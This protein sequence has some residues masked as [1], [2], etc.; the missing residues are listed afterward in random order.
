MGDASMPEVTVD[1]NELRSKSGNE[2]VEDLVTFLREQLK[3]EVDV[4][5]DTLSVNTEKHTKPYV[6]TVLRKF[7]HRTE[8]KEDFRVI[9]GKEHGFIIKERKV[10]KEEE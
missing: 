6:R 4:S 3:T 9:A 1:T 5:G 8:L 7:L 2:A 10:T